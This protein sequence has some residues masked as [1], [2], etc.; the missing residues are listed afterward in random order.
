MNSGEIVLT[1]PAACAVCR[2]SI[3]HG[4]RVWWDAGTGE[5]SCVG[6]HIGAAAVP[7]MPSGPREPYDEERSRVRDHRLDPAHREA[8]RWSPEPRRDDRRDRY[9]DRYEDRHRDRYDPRVDVR[10]DDRHVDR[11]DDRARYDD[12]YDDRARYDDRQTDSHD[13]RSVDRRGARSSAQHDEPYDDRY[14]DHRGQRTADPYDLREDRYGDPR[15]DPRRDHRD[16]PRYDPRSDD[17][18]APRD[19]RTARPDVEPDPRPQRRWDPLD[20]DAPDWWSSFDPQSMAP[21]ADRGERFDGRGPERGAGPRVDPLTVPV[22]TRPEPVAA[23]PE[24]AVARPEP[25]V[26]RPEPVVTRPEPVVADPIARQDPFPSADS[27]TWAMPPDGG[28]RRHSGLTTVITPGGIAGLP[29]AHRRTRLA[30]HRATWDSTS[31]LHLALGRSGVMLDHRVAPGDARVLDHVV[32]AQSGVWV[33]TVKSSRGLVERRAGST[34]AN[35]RDRLLVD[36]RERNRAVRSAHLRTRA[37][38]DAVARLGNGWEQV[39]VRPMLCY[40]DAEWRP[41]AQPFEVDGVAVL[42]P[43]QLGA[44]VT[45]DPVISPRSVEALAAHLDSTLRRP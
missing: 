18:F 38:A 40:V 16:E 39:P 41:F 33:V 36:G 28:R 10:H 26:T 6:P 1:F 4:T 3:P 45:T 12:R 24:P 19:D 13:D 27:A 30:R 11:Y 20:I 31:L 14:S 35:T 22:V 29:P 5:V 32:I 43:K 34:M 37:V 42:W 2:A 7:T 9:E 8:D 23:R 15:T 17:R 25:V 44:F 21:P